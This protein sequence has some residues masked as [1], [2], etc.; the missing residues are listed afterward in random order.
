MTDE[1][2]HQGTICGDGAWS[3]SP[4]TATASRSR[5]PRSPSAR[6]SRSPISSS[7]SPSCAPP[8]WSRACAVRAAAI[9][10]PTAPT[11][12]RISDI[13]LAVDEPIR[14]T[15]CTPGA[16]IGCCG[17]KSRCL[18]H[19]LWEELGNQIHLYLS[20]VTLADV[21]EQPRARQQ[22]RAPSRPVRR[23]ARRPRRS[24]NRAV[25]QWSGPVTQRR[26]TYLDWNATAPLRPE[27]RGGDGRGAGALRQ[28][29]V[30]ASLGAR[31]R[32]AARDSARARW[33]RWPALRPTQVV[34]TSGGTEANHLALRGFAGA[35]RRSCRRS[36]MIRCCAAAP[37]AAR[38]R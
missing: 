31:A 19:D 38:C 36:S 34:F 5:W 4:S 14:A 35:A 3:T 1:T 32:Q 27:A 8:V 33:R 26:A 17:N 10:W 29:V 22:R 2:Q 7:S 37:A 21:C 15:R 30:G 25:D 6:R 23:D 13:I 24:N 9:C 11:S 12:T 18:T 28:S 16:P 20:S